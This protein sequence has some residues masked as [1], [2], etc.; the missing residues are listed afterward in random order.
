LGIENNNKEKQGEAHKML[1]DIYSRNGQT[2]VAFQH[3]EQVLEIAISTEKKNAE[4]EAALKLGLLYNKDGP[5]RNIKKSSDYLQSH[6]DL[7]RSPDTK[8]QALL[9]SARV[10]LGIVQ[11]NMK[12][13][14]YKQMV[15]GNLNGL[16]DWKVRREHKH[17]Q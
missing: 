5:E 14:A 1:A 8:N 13:E 17:F 9:D 7:L 15:L 10:N 3:L 16:V 6:F 4:A 12:I 11:A 2:S